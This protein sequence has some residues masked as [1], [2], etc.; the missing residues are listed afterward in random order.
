MSPGGARVKGGMEK[1]IPLVNP[2]EKGKVKMTDAS[3][4][5]KKMTHGAGR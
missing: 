1:A 2:G 3:A 5:A 4:N